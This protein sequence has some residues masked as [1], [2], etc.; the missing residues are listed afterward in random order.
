[1]IS[2]IED[3]PNHDTKSLFDIQHIVRS[4]F[5]SRRKSV[6]N[7]SI[8]MWNRT[9]G[10]EETLEYPEDL[11]KVLLVLRSMTDVQLPSLHEAEVDQVRSDQLA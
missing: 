2:I 3:M 4:G 7:Q 9:F 11:C 5:K 6:L 10:C 8:T 1:M